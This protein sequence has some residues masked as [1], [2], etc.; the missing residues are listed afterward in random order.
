MVSH[1]TEVGPSQFWGWRCTPKLECI[2][3]SL[4]DD[5]TVGTGEC[6]CGYGR[7]KLSCMVT[8]EMFGGMVVRTGV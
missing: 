8:E 1:G 4:E 2:V 7:T 3:G 6:D 5:E